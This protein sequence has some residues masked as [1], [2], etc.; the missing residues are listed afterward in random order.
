M[1]ERDFK[2]LLKAHAIKQVQ[3]HYAVMAPG[4]MIVINGHPLAHGV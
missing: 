3:V 2:I 4:Y 1:I